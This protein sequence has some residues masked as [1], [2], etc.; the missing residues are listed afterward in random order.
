MHRLDLRSEPSPEPV[1]ELPRAALVAGLARLAEED[2]VCLPLLDPGQR[3]VW[4]AE[5]E[6]HRYRDARPVIGSGTRSVYQDFE[7]G[8]TFPPDSGFHAF[9]AALEARLHDALA[10]LDPCPLQDVVLNDL[11]LQRYP[12]GS[13]GITPHRD[14]VRYVG[15]VAIVTL[16]GR[17]R[18]FL[19]ND[20]GGAGA[21]E[22]PIPPG[23]LCL[24][25]APG[26]AGLTDRPFHYLSDVGETGRIS[27]GIR[28]DTRPG[29]P[30]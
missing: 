2:A 3:A 5:A 7:V 29:D 27:L 19:C 21:R 8:V 1:F 14:H 18:F 17:A 23:G 16:A 9:A 6:R 4:L 15:L 10:A 25:R 22:I 20:R 24:M 11:I 13:R 30:L 12:A 28:H 26:F